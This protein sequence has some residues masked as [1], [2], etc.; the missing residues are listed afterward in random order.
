MRIKDKRNFNS[1]NDISFCNH[2]YHPYYTK[3]KIWVFAWPVFDSIRQLI[4][5]LYTDELKMQD[6]MLTRRISLFFL[7]TLSVVAG[8]AFDSYP[9]FGAM[10]D[11]PGFKEKGRYNPWFQ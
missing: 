4:T 7:T 2:S 1:N 10:G 11:I 9:R 6:K 3:M 8:G 5:K